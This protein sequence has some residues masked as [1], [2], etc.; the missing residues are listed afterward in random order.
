MQAVVALALAG[1]VGAVYWQVISR[2]F[3]YDDWYI[4]YSIH[5]H[6]VA[7]TITNA[8]IPFDKLIY[9]PLAMV[10]YAVVFKMFGLNP[11][12]FHLL[13]LVLHICNSGLVAFVLFRMSGM[14]S[15]AIA[16][17]ILYAGAASVHL[18]P[19]LWL[20]GFY[21]IAGMFFLLLSFAFF[22]SKKSRLSIASFA[23]ALLTKE[24]TFFFVGVLVVY[25]VLWERNQFRRL[26][27][28]LV[29]SVLYAAIKT[30]GKSALTIDGAHPHRLDV[31]GKHITMNLESYGRWL[32][33]SLF[34][35]IHNS[36][37]LLIG[38]LMILIL[39]SVI[40]SIRSSGTTH[41]LLNP[42]LVMFFL[43]WL[44]VGI[45]P[46]LFLRNQAAR[47]YAI[48]SLVPFLF[49]I[50]YAISLVVPE[51]RTAYRN[52]LL[53]VTVVVSLLAN[54][55]YVNS[56]FARGMNEVVTADGRFHLIQK[57]EVVNT[58]H[59]ALMEKHPG[60]PPHATLVISGP[61]L[62]AIGKGI[63]PKFWY[64]DTTLQVIS[65]V[66]YYHLKESLSTDSLANRDFYFLNLDS[67]STE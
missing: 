4:L 6:D 3:V 14:K 38:G 46:V 49:L 64:N 43:I 47:Y 39:L 62:M 32:A 20:V 34:P 45:L 56:L 28:H 55:F 53:S 58:L 44:V 15:G 26:Y 54:A 42:K 33:D 23:F 10:Y 25:V 61:G 57:G 18:D 41:R 22:L 36:S 52:A 65:L 48:Y 7:T 19:L 1:V 24:S 27:P 66:E 31:W 59:S 51:S 21:D 13:A 16:A 60:L 40:Q 29:V 67:S 30:M 50:V 9:R 11:V 5:T 8:F 17:A 2:P 12:P 37:L 35:S 63:A